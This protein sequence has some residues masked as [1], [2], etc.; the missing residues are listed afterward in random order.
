MTISQAAGQMSSTDV[1]VVRPKINTLVDE[2]IASLPAH[3]A[4]THWRERV[5]A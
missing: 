5:S 1:D 3:A 4:Q 2:A